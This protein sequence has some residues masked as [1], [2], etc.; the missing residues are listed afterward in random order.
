MNI[1]QP[2]VI[3]EVKT[4]E[5]R[6]D[7]QEVLELEWFENKKQKLTR[8]TSSGLVLEL[9]LPHQQEWQQG[10]LLYSNGKL[11]ATISIKDCL[12]ICFPAKNDQDAADF[13][14]FIGNQ[15]LPVFLIGIQEFAVPYDGRLYEQLSLRYNGRIELRDTQLLSTQSL[16][17]LTKNKAHEN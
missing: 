17:H 14:Y 4:D 1:I 8:A 3:D 15:H 2:V 7:C 13:C 16:R 5:N 12:T 11:V 9:R 6:S 10:D